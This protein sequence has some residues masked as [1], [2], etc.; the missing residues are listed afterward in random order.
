MV[1]PFALLSVVFLNMFNCHGLGPVKY[2]RNMAFGDGILITVF[3]R[4]YQQLISRRPC[5]GV[6]I[7]ASVTKALSIGLLDL[8]QVDF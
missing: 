5:I 4:D 2:G 3:C 6:Y 1:N 7:D 8:N